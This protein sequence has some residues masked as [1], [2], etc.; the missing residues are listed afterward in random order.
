VL[1]LGIF[2]GVVGFI[3]SQVEGTGVASFTSDVLTN[4]GAGLAG[5]A[6]TFILFQTLFVG[7]QCGT[8]ANSNYDAEARGEY[9]GSLNG[10]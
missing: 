6:V 5:A 9:E 3:Y 1:V 8:S 2:L 10:A 7:A 4:L